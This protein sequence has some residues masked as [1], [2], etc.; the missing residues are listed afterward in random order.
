MF[1]CA[2][3]YGETLPKRR[4]YSR[5]CPSR[6]S[7]RGTAICS[8]VYLYAGTLL[9]ARSYVLIPIWKPYKGHGVNFKNTQVLQILEAQ[10]G[11]LSSFS[12]SSHERPF[13]EGIYAHGK[14]HKSSCS[15][16]KYRKVLQKGKNYG[17]VPKMAQI[18]CC[19]NLLQ[20]FLQKTTLAKF[21]GLRSCLLIPGTPRVLCRLHDSME[22][23]PHRFSEVAC[24]LRLSDG[25]SV[26][27]SLN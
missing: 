24:A 23:N 21:S 27:W 1:I 7:V 11:M 15:V 2:Y 8:C 12:S 19:P 26:P 4:F 14:L 25:N 18:Q 10:A 17:E 5:L 6:D 20:I 22:R 16:G 9:E 3:L 13:K